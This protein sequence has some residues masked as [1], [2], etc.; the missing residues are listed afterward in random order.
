[1]FL[2]FRL[3]F[4]GVV[5]G[6]GLRYRYIIFDF[7]FFLVV[8]L[9]IFGRLRFWVWGVVFFDLDGFRIAYVRLFF[10]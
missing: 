6:L 4:L 3:G 7:I 8:E 5:W 2:K 9:S 10:L 1:M